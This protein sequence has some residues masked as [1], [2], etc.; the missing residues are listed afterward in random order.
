MTAHAVTPVARLTPAA[1]VKRR[2]AEADALPDQLAVAKLLVVVA[3]QQHQAVVAKRLLVAAAAVPL[4]LADVRSR[5]VAVVVAQHLAAVANNPLAAAVQLQVV[6]VKL[7]PAIHAASQ[8]VSRCKSCLPSSKLDA[9]RVAAIVAASQAVV[10]K[11]PLAVVAQ[12]QAVAAVQH[13]AVA[14]KYHP[15]THVVAVQLLAADV[16][17]LAATVD[18]QARKSAAACCRSCSRRRARMVAVT[19]SLVT[20]DADALLLATAVDR[21]LY[22][23]PPFTATRLQCLQHR[24]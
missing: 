18:V 15:V 21:L 14:V 20:Q 12:L 17:L 7:Q 16:K 10:A 3:V 22:P 24:S 1:D 2:L 9:R 23:L 19:P 11:L 4:R 13:L 5:L 6:V 8:S